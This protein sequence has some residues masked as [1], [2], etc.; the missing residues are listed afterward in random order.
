MGIIANSVATKLSQEKIAVT[1]GTLRKVSTKLKKG[2]EHIRRRYDPLANAISGPNEGMLATAFP[3]DSTK[4]IDFMSNAYSKLEGAAI[5][6]E[7]RQSMEKLNKLSGT[8]PRIFTKGDASSYIGK[9]LGSTAG[10]PQTPA[11]REAFNRT[12][13]LHELAELS[14]K[15]PGNFRFSSHLSVKPALQDLNIA[16]T[17]AGPGSNAAPLLKKMR[18]GD[19][20][21]LSTVIPNID[22]VLGQQR[23]SRHAMKRIQNAW[24]RGVMKEGG[25]SPLGSGIVPRPT[26]EIKKLIDE[27]PVF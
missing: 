16:T 5:G 6:R 12:V 23:I 10:L 15:Q 13:F 22:K 9:Q 26:S 8:N 4:L 11:G 17:L 27:M 2:V 14:N 7:V 24:D 20:E 18:E 3:S 1:L 21:L 19:I 25:G